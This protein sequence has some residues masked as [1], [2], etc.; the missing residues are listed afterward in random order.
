MQERYDLH[1]LGLA[2]CAGGAPPPRSS[3]EVYVYDVNGDL[4][5]I[6][7]ASVSTIPF[8]CVCPI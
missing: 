1:H 3:T 5:E 2:R 6:I 7:I 4:L 8:R